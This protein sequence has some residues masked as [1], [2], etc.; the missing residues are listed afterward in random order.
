MKWMQW[1]M[2][3]AL[4]AG[5]GLAGL[6]CSD[7]DDDSSDSNLLVGTWTAQSYNG[8][9]LGT[10]SLRLTFHSN[11]DLEA[12]T[13]IDGVSE[14]DSGT[15]SAQN[16]ILTTVIDGEQDTTPYTVNGNTLTMG[17]AGDVFVLKR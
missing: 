7:N 16:G 3:L 13:T 4:G 5:M 14:T 10:V 17:R 2:V 9:S 12:R 15:W 6:G 11:G 1:V 8:A